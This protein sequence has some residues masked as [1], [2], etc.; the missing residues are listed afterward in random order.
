MESYKRPVKELGVFVLNLMDK[1]GNIYY[2]RDQVSQENSKIRP[3]HIVVRYHIFNT[4]AS[5]KAC[6]DALAAI[7]NE[8]YV[9]GHRRGKI[10]LASTRS[11]LIADVKNINSFLGTELEK[12]QSWINKITNYR[13]A[14][15]H[16]IMLLTTIVGKPG[17]LKCRVPEIPISVA[18]P[19][20]SYY[21]RKEIST[22]DAEDFCNELIGNVTKLIEIVCLDLI[23]ML[24]SRTYI[25]T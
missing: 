17:L 24:S 4:I 5:C 10:D 20:I 18:D 8:V 3:S 7:L 9:L 23:S 6:F 12:Y 22:T 2:A 15:E 1:L 11:D 16:R 14:M 13:D 21:E 19:K 25:P